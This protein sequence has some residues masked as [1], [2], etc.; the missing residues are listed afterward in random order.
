MV[1]PG[2]AARVVEWGT[3]RGQRK[4]ASEE[5]LWFLYFFLNDLFVFER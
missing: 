5:K 4:G 2:A 3:F 1:N